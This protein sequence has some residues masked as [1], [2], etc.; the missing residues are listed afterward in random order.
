LNN[1]A[2]KVSAACFLITFNR[3]NVMSSAQHIGSKNAVFYLN[4]GLS[5][6][7]LLMVGVSSD[8]FWILEFD[9]GYI[10]VLALIAIYFTANI[11]GRA[12]GRLAIEKQFNPYLTGI[13]SGFLIV[14]IP[15]MLGSSIGFFAEGISVSSNIYEALF[16]YIFKPIIVIFIFGGVPITVIGL[17]YGR[18]LKRK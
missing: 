11:I 13:V 6:A 4:I 7:Y 9:Y 17:F 16:D 1:Q 18:S 10:V 14:L 2:R 12:A 8:F 5:I 15:T 3:Q